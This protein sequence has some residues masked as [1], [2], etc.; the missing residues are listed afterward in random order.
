MD[1][2]RDL[3]EGGRI[4]FIKREPPQ[5]FDYGL[6]DYAVDRFSQHFRRYGAD[7]SVVEEADPGA[8]EALLALCRDPRLLF[9]YSFDGAGVRLPWP[10]ARRNG[11][12]TP[13]GDYRVPFLARVSNA[14][15]AENS[16]SA[17]LA[18]TDMHLVL[19]RDRNSLGAADR[20]VKRGTM[21]AWLMGGALGAGSAPGAGWRA[22]RDRD[23]PLLV[24][25]RNLDPAFWRTAARRRLGDDAAHFDAALDAVVAGPHLCIA[26]TA[27]AVLAERGAGDEWPREHL[28][29]FLALVN[30]T[31]IAIR[32]RRMLELAAPYPAVYVLETGSPPARLHPRSVAL[33][34]M[35][36]AD[37]VRLIARSRGY[38]CFNPNGMAGAFTERI[39]QAVERG[40]IPLLQENA[41]TAEIFSE[42]GGLSV[43]PGDDA[44]RAGIERLLEPSGLSEM[45][46]AGHA[47]MRRRHTVAGFVGTILAAAARRSPDGAL[48]R[49][50]ERFPIA[51]LAE[52]VPPAGERGPSG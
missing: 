11:A 45:A 3:L 18:P 35:K 38:L 41:V 33:R 42:G 27:L 32:R 14:L 7:I 20:L 36:N 48:A 50:L 39:G 25:T 37:L 16:R 4:A 15:F 31:A 10:G 22:M 26:S 17:V 30:G 52:P 28:F 23:I 13:F 21:A 5:G 49:R 29:R 9:A 24:A 12:E 8:A 6:D 43:G 34:R 19:V 2:P 1:L 46:E 51:S 47:S 40:T 44:M